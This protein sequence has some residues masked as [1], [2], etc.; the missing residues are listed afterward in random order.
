MHRLVGLDADTPYLREAPKDF[1]MWSRDAF[2][3]RCNS[4][5]GQLALLRAAASIGI[6]Q[7]PLACAH[8]LVRVPSDVKRMLPLRLAMDEALR[9]SPGSRRSFEAVAEGLRSYCEGTSAKP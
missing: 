7:Q 1:P 8:S 6:C 2:A 5:L 3:L 9:A 4:D